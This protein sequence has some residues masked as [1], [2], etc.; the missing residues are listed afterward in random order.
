M[1][2]ETQKVEAV[3]AAQQQFPKPRWMQRRL[4]LSIVDFHYRFEDSYFPP[5]EYR[6][7]KVQRQ[8]CTFC[9]QSS[10]MIVV[11]TTCSDSTAYQ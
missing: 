9:S 11:S 2:V 7:N 3:Q 5:F 8:K 6:F 4:V 10:E 1:A